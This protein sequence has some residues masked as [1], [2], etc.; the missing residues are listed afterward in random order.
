MT[1]LLRLLVQHHQHI[2]ALLHG[3][4]DRLR[5]ADSG[6]GADPDP[7]DHDL[8]IVDLIA[9]EL[10]AVRQFAHLP[11][12][13]H[14]KE[15]LFADLIEQFA[16]MSLATLDQRGEHEDL[17]AVVLFQDEINDLL[18]AVP[19][20]LLSCLVRVGVGDAGV[21]EPH[22]VVDLGD[23]ADRRSGIPAGRFLLDRDDGAQPVDLVDIGPLEVA[24]ELPGIHGKGLHVPA[25]TLG[26]NGVERERRF[27][28]AAQPGE[29]HQLV[30]RDHQVGVLQIVDACAVNF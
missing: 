2:L 14:M 4:G 5:Q 11:V 3:K 20:H 12:D 8:D 30:A 1:G 26:V 21:Q 6:S 25:L 16:V 9:V 7:V 18:L 24:D 15:S 23:G 28:A 22:E 10:H 27:P 13:P 17:L 29:D 19:H